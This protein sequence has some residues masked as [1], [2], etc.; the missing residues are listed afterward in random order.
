VGLGVDASDQAE[1]PYYEA[2]LYDAA[3]I[4]LRR[5]WFDPDRR[6]RMIESWIRERRGTLSTFERA[7]IDVALAAVDRLVGVGPTTAP[8]PQNTAPTALSRVEF[9]PIFDV[10]RPQSAFEVSFPIGVIWG[11]LGLAATFATRVVRERE[12]GTLVR[13]RVAPI[14]R[15]H[16]LAGNGMATFVSCIGVTVLLLLVGIGLFD[17]RLQS[18]SVVAVAVVCTAL[19]FVGVTM[20]LSVLG[21]TE[22]S[23]GGAAWAFLLVMA[24]LGGGMVPQIF[25]PR[26]MDIASN[27]SF[28]KWAVRGLEGGIWRGL[29]LGEI[30]LPAA[31]LLVQGAFFAAAGLFIGS[32]TQR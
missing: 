30:W 18:L 1:A 22:T 19:C 4:L 32:R 15:G 29:T 7:S 16:I 14:R 8:S 23:V 11:L 31:L 28:V 12:M 9:I 2:A 26:W 6:P 25:L 10:Y 5:N 21:N 27:V 24:L 3:M 13:L 20:F 17:V